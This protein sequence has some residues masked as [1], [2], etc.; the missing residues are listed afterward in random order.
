MHNAALAHALSEAKACKVHCSAVAALA[1]TNL[2]AGCQI[3]CNMLILHEY[4]S[5]QL[6]H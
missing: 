1:R 2:F 3:P 5:L 6:Q 4:P